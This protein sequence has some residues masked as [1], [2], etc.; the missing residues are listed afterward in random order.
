VT[1]DTINAV[2]EALGS[3]AVW[4]N[5]FA[6]IKDKGYAGT[7]IPMMLFF[8]AW[9][10]WNLWYYPH[11]GQSLSFYASVLLTTGNCAVLAAMAYFGRKG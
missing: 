9:G 4:A 8:S 3:V 11:L 2:F 1:P 6:I 10:F 5:V 7:R